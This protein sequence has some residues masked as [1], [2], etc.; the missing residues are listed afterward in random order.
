MLKKRLLGICFFLGFLGILQ[1]QPTAHTPLILKK[2]PVKDTLTVANYKVVF[3]RVIADSRCPKGI[4]CIWEG[5]VVFELEVMK[6]DTLMRTER[7]TMPPSGYTREERQTVM[8]NNQTGV[9]IY[10]L[11]PVPVANKKTPKAAYYLQLQVF[12]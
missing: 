5:E 8:L 3:T 10:N 6:S 4:T 7:I 12:N 11:M 2:L 9:H 1:A